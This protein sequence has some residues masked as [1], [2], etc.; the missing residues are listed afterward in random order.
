MTNIK[1]ATV[2]VRIQENVKTQA[3]AIFNKLGLSRATAIDLF[4]RQIIM[5]NGFPFPLHLKNNPILSREDMTYEEFNDFMRISL[6]QARNGETVSVDEAFE[7]L[8]RGL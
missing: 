2:N 7:Q 8:F 1:T 4:Y 6:E 5:S 3:E